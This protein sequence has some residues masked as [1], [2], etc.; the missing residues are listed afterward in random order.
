MGMAYLS[1]G[2]NVEP[3]R[4]LRAAVA[5]L[6]ARFGEVL[7]SPVYRTRSVGFDGTDFLN[8]AAVIDSDLDPFALNDWLHALEDA[9]GRDRSG[10]RFSDRTL[11]IDIVLYDDLVLQGPGNLRLPRDELKHAFVLLP[12]VD[13]APE[14]VEPRSGRTLAALWREH[15][16]H[17]TPPQAVPF[18]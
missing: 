9:H 3:E 8:A 17:A 15:P 16:D 4:H 5:A 10:P 7:L 1:L 11:D 6:R 2:S 12:L 13:I 14:A 18:P